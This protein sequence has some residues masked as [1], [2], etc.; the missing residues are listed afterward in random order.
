MYSKSA[1]YRWPVR[2]LFPVG[3][4]HWVGCG[5]GDNMPPVTCMSTLLHC[6]VRILYRDVMSRCTPVHITVLV[7]GNR[8][9]HMCSRTM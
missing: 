7:V 2:L 4:A 6:P 1:Y 3:G 9:S 5:C 8:M